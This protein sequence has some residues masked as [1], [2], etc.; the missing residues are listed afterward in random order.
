MQEF[1][2]NANFPMNNRAHGQKVVNPPMEP[3]FG[4]VVDPAI[5]KDI[6]K[7][8]AS[9]EEA[10]CFLRSLFS[11]RSFCGRLAPAWAFRPLP[12]QI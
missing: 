11:S 5:V 2:I 9:E 6:V 7:N 4:H 10:S 3:S 12:L 1:A 8:T